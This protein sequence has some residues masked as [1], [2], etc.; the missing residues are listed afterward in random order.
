MP[1]QE[2]SR[3]WEA[4]YQAHVLSE[5]ERLVTEYHD[6]RAFMEDIGKRLVESA[7]LSHSVDLVELGQEEEVLG[8]LGRLNPNAKDSE[9]QGLVSLAKWSISLRTNAPEGFGDRDFEFAHKSLRNNFDRL[10]FRPVR[11]RG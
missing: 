11:N 2:L 9:R 5:L 3:T 8:I 6:L 4:E 10:Y 7:I 1:E